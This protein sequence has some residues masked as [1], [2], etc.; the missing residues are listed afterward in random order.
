MW[1]HN[2]TFKNSKACLSRVTA[3]E[4]I[5]LQQGNG[6]CRQLSTK[7][8]LSNMLMHQEPRTLIKGRVLTLPPSLIPHIWG[9][10]CI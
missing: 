6:F 4:T 2:L 8:E 9:V 5:L 3:E 10:L 1:R 7:Q